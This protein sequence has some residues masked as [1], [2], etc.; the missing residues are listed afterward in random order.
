MSRPPRP[1]FRTT[2]TGDGSAFA[3]RK[4]FLPT[5]FAKMVELQRA[6][7]E[8][9]A[10]LGVTEEEGDFAYTLM[11]LAALV[12]HTLGLY[13]NL[14]ARDAYLST[15]ETARSL[16]LQA[17]RLAYEP[18]QGLA[19]SGFAVLTVGPGLK[20]SV[21][22]RFALASSPRGEVKAQTFETL[23]ALNVD[24]ARNAAL[25]VASRRAATLVFTARRGSFRLAGTGLP[26]AQSTYG[27]LDRASD[28]LWLPVHVLEL[29]EDLLREETTVEVELLEPTS[30]HANATFALAAPDLTP[31]LRFRAMPKER[32]QR[33]GWNA[34]PVQFPPGELRDRGE[35][36]GASS[37]TTPNYGYTVALES[38]VTQVRDEDV[39]LGGST[40]T[41]LLGTPVVA[42]RNNQIEA[43]RVVE[44]GAASVAFHRGLTISYTIGVDS[45]G[46]PVPGSSPLETEITGTVTYLRL[47]TAAEV[48]S[49]R[50][51][52]ALQTSFH[53]DWQFDAAVLATEPNPGLIAAPLEVAADYG[54]F[55][56]GGFAV[57]ETLDG[58]F[59]QV[60]EIQRLTVT[61]GGTTNLS[62]VELTDPP[63]DGWSLDDLRVF[64]NVA[65][66]THGETIEE[67]L[68]GSDGVTP[69]LRFELK[70]APLTQVP[71]PDGGEPA[72]EVRV[73]DVE[74]TRVDDFF[75][76][77]EEDRH[78]QLEI[79]ESQK[80][81]VVFGSGRRG[82]GADPPGM[83]T[84]GGGGA[85]PPSGRKHIRAVYRQGLGADGNAGRGAVGR[86]KKAHPLIEHAVNP[87]P[88]IG[89]AAPAGFKDLQRQATR[90]IR[91]FDRAVSIQDHADLALLYPGV[92]RAAARWAGA[93]LEVTV[94]TADGGP[95]PMDAVEAF[96]N[97]RRDSTLPMVVSP[98]E[99]VDLF[100]DLT[101]EHDP[102]YLTENV[103]RAVQNALFGSDHDAPGMFTFPARELGQAAH[104]SE[105]YDRVASVQAVTFVDVTR[106]R[107][108]N[109]SGVMD[110]L[111]V[112]AG[113]WLRLSPS[114]L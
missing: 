3:G 108:E 48:E 17:R 112:K 114:H 15:A 23:D 113:Q 76:S 107:I 6:L 57:F 53:A 39:Y 88:T 24:A 61:A 95:P 49:V 73:N 47:E 80:V 62:W 41:D 5:E 97:A 26:L 33:F 66:V 40:T 54:D 92:A 87:S 19:A 103:K 105:V 37:T 16:V 102:G 81:S 94:A 65:R 83:S 50:A 104:L 110:V 34:D 71:G 38:G 2:T 1:L 43:L 72:I 84:G 85:I 28:E 100:L 111:Q 42:R 106:F 75:H 31:M 58:T 56:P 46:N 7:A 69:F 63:P 4:Q 29:H 14:Y 32:L 74:W 8:T 67:V 30:S 70:K 12:G 45:G 90:F 22:A 10:R 36:T 78:Y 77:T 109:Q 96:L 13:Q 35:Y 20:G 60:V 59:G 11:E 51:A 68:G 27:I 82:T 18:D 99:T 93:G 79:D 52:L 9:E 91:T 89:G 98:P 25:P 21:P 86:I 55:R 64:G 44:Q 101:V